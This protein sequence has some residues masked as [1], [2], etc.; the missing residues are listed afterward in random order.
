MTVHSRPCIGGK[1]QMPSLPRTSPR[2][3]RVLRNA[4]SV[5]RNLEKGT[6]T[7]LTAAGVRQ[8]HRR[9]PNQLVLLSHRIQGMH[10]RE[11]RLTG[12][13]RP[14]AQ[15]DLLVQP[16]RP[17]EVSAAV[18]AAGTNDQARSPASSPLLNKADSMPPENRCPWRLIQP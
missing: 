5:E 1:R 11:R 12:R 13:D 4:G 14:K 17:L 18:N 15:R 7:V 6:T 9:P 16:G 3:C 8:A 2:P 10:P